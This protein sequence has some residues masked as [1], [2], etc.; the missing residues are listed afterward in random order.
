MAELLAMIE[1][2]DGHQVQQ[3]VRSFSKQLLEDIPEE[4]HLQVLEQLHDNTGGFE[5]VAV[6]TS[7]PYHLAVVA[8]AKK[9]RDRY[10]A[11]GGD[12]RIESEPGQGTK[13]SFTFPISAEQ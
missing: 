10:L 6:E 5:V 2:T 13:V 1:T 3:F 8:R 9:N 12:I 7:S 4:R 11:H